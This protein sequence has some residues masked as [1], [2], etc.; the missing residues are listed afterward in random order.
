MIVPQKPELATGNRLQP[1]AGRPIEHLLRR[2]APVRL[3]ARL[4]AR[5][6]DRALLAGAD[7]T[8]SRQL[9]ARV[10]ALTSP[11]SR[12]A[13]ADGLERWLSAAHGATSA[14]RLLPPRALALDN[15]SEARAILSL[16]RG[17]VPLYAHGIALL[18]S[19]L[20]DGTGPAYV[21]ESDVLARLLGEVRATMAGRVP[22]NERPM[23][24]RPA[25]QSAR[26]SQ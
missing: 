11:R 3:L 5:A 13:T 20:S 2:G 15:A 26:A 23:A 10:Q 6:L 25:S 16:L 9:A 21:G 18:A 1:L 24:L 22:A 8:Q 4:R 7:P 17:S 12:A 19:L 14:R